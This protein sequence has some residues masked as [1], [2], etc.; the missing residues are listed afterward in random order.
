MGPSALS[1]GPT[2]GAFRHPGDWPVSEK[3]S[4]MTT[5]DGR[6]TSGLC[7]RGPGEAIE[8]LYRDPVHGL[9][10]RRPCP[11]GPTVGAFRH[12]DD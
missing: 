3:I 9:M 6:V 11:K 4:Q 12:P 7:P 10:G 1:E 2:V 5:S 8:V